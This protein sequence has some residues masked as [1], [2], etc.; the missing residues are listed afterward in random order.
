MCLDISEK[1]TEKLRQRLAKGH[2]RL[3]KVFERRERRLLSMHRKAEYIAGWN[4]SYRPR[5]RLT[6]N[7]KLFKAVGRGV[8]VYITK[9]AASRRCRAIEGNVLVPVS[10]KPE[11]LVAGGRFMNS[12]SAVFTKVYMDPKDYEKAVAEGATG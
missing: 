9:F 11:D 7:E 10:V 4:R 12:W 2:T 3:W 8:H 5:K 1:I 6:A